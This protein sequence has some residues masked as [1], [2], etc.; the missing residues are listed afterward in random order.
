MQAEAERQRLWAELAQA[1]KMESIGRL[2]GGIAHDF[3]NILADIT[4]QAGLATTASI[5]R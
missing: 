4:A 3:N 5:Q 1:Q 2:A